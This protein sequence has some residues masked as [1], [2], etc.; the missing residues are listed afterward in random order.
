MHSSLSPTPDGATFIMKPT[1]RGGQLNFKPCY[2]CDHCGRNS[3]TKVRCFKL[4]GYP[5]KKADALAKTTKTK[6]YTM[7]LPPP[8]TQEHYNK[9]L[10]ML[11]SG[12]INS[13]V[14]LA[15]IVRTCV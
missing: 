2:H 5:Q 3:H 12:S 6:D 15:G 7:V 10:A 14:S 8:I 1:N 13:S 4:V 11:S 9:L